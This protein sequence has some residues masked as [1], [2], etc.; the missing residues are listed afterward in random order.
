MKSLL[1]LSGLPRTGTTVL[2]S[3]L[4]QNPNV[5]CTSTSGLLDLL[6][7]V[8]YVYN[9][10]SNRSLEFNE[11]QLKNIFK[12]IATGYYLHINQP[13]VI[14]KWRG[15]IANIP[16]IKEIITNTPKIICTYRPIEEIVTS[17]LYL[18]E[19]DV[20]N[21][22]DKELALKSIS[23]TNSNRAKYLWESGVIG[24]TYSFFVDSLKYKKEICYISYDE[25]VS[26]PDKTI[27][28]IYDYLQIEK[29]NHHYT[30]IDTTNL[31]NDN[32]WKIKNLHTIR[33]NLSKKDKSPADYLTTKDI[34][35]FKCFNNVF[36]EIN[37][38]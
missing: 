12:S 14:D 33:S 9:E 29:Y 5:H 30:N 38:T 1:F 13:I 20:D 8:N 36:S 19:N 21:F 37:H 11:Y 23:I 15:W 34:N 10:V 17:F 2:S 25:I 6:S 32:Y 22:V 3:I 35:F 31:D 7:G 4:N 28:K 27:E 16:Q 24:E 26:Y 18:L